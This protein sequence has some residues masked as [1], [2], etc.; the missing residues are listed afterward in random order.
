MKWIVDLFPEQT[1]SGYRAMNIRCFQRDNGVSKS[2]V[3]EDLNVTQGGFDHCFRSRCSIF[4]EQVFF[5][6]S[7]IDTD[8]DWDPL[9]L[10]SA[11][12]FANAFVLANVS[13]IQAELVDPGV[14]SH[15][16]QLV[17]EMNIGNQ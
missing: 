11:H 4:C 13:G 15:Q 12:Y 2:E 17:M 5:Q 7:S 10:G 16:C 6:R 1:I 3:F 9:C 8:A 14:Q